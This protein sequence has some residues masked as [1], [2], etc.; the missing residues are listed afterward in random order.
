MIEL[1]FG[2]F[3]FPKRTIYLTSGDVCDDV[4]WIRRT[5]H[6][7]VELRLLRKIGS[8]IPTA[9]RPVSSRLLFEV[10]RHGHAVQMRLNSWSIESV[11]CDVQILF[12]VTRRFFRPSPKL[13][14]EAA[15]V[16]HCGVVRS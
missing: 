7:R 3:R 2:F 8:R 4:F 6:R 5:R 10:R 14:A 1:L 15:V 12:E 16:N 13:R 11:R 9:S